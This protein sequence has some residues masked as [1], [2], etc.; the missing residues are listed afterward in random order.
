MGIT[1]FS[2]LLCDNLPLIVVT[3]S[4][5]PHLKDNYSRTESVSLTV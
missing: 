5:T 2:C 1:T 4:D 3:S